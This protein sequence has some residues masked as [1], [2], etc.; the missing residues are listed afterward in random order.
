MSVSE[1]FRDRWPKDWPLQLV[2]RAAWTQ[3]RPT[4]GQAQPAIIN[5]ALERSQRR[6]TGNWYVFAASTDVRPG[7]PLGARVAG[8]EL[9]AWRDRLGHLTVGPASCPHLGADLATGTVADGVLFCR[10]HGLALDG[11][12]C[13]LGW[14]TLPS[15]DDGVLAWVRL[16]AVG[17][18]TPLD[19][20]VIP[21]RPTGTTLPAVARVDGTCEPQ[22]IIANRL[23]P[24]HGGWFHPYSFTR[25]EVLTTPT[26]EDDRFVVSVTFRVG[27]FGVPTIAEFTCPEARTIVMRI[28]EGEGAGSVVETHATP[29]GPGPDGRPRVAVIEA[30]VAHSQRPGFR[31]ALSVAPL[32]TPL[33]RYAANRLWRDDLAYAERRYR[34]RSGG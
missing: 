22:D 4:Y 12:S 23:D 31:A 25:L 10:W 29:I 19:V 30:V 34:L 17:G 5:A 32:V 11:K 14:A 9:V 1:Q 20:P 13:K 7:R 15:Y 21:D 33:M 18:E 3:Q 2:P 27:R 16:D 8:V 24:W 26:E 6:P 28:V